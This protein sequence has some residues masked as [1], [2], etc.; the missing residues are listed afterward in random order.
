[1]NVMGRLFINKFIIHAKYAITSRLRKVVCYSVFELFIKESKMPAIF[2]NIKHL[3]MEYLHYMLSP[4]TKEL[5]KNVIPK[6]KMKRG[7]TTDC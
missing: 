7:L 4:F 1:M 3:A 2:V 5:L 6:S